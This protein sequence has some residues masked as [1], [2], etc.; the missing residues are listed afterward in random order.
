V[1]GGQSLNLYSAKGAQICAGQYLPIELEESEIHL[2]HGLTF[3]LGTR[4]DTINIPMGNYGGNDRVAHINQKEGPNF[5]FGFVIL[6]NLSQMPRAA[7][8]TPAWAGM[9]AGNNV[10]GND[11]SQFDLQYLA[12]VWMFWLGLCRWRD[13]LK[14]LDFV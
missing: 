4:R 11:C 6:G 8:G 10:A 1:N 13:R 2:M 9:P 14:L 3:L 5:D 7:Y 12:L